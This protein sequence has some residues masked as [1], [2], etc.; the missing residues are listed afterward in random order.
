MKRYVKLQE[1]QIK[2]Q[3][4][5]LRA[6]VAAP[7][8]AIKGIIYSAV[9][10]Q[11]QE[12]LFEDIINLNKSRDYTTADAR[13]LGKTKSLLITFIG[14]NEVPREII[15]FGSIY[16]CCPFKAKVETCFNCRRAGHRAGVCPKEK[17]DLCRRCGEQH[18]VKEQPDCTP[19][20]ILCNRDHFT[21]TRKCKQRFERPGYFKGRTSTSTEN[22]W[23]RG[24]QSKDRR[25]ESIASPGANSDRAPGQEEGTAEAAPT[26]SHPSGGPRAR[27]VQSR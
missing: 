12:E 21:G 1:L 5:P 23:Q 17:T 14:T 9:Y 18:P 8:D 2:D 19:K 26:P 10:D 13:Q 4:H 27:N 22:P 6:Y 7:D 20:C 3:Q 16:T 15:F 25:A 11:T 24:Q